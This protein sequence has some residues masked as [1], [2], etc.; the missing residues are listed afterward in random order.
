MSHNGTKLLYFEADDDEE[1]LSNSPPSLD[2]YCVLSLI[3]ERNKHKEKIIHLFHLASLRC[4]LYFQQQFEQNTPTT[5]T[6]YRE[7]IHTACLLYTLIS[8]THALY[9]T[10]TDLCSED[11]FNNLMFQAFNMFE[12][13]FTLVKEFNANFKLTICFDETNL[14]QIQFPMSEFVECCLFVVS[15]FEKNLELVKGALETTIS[16]FSY[17]KYRV[18]GDQSLSIFHNSC[19][20]KCYQTMLDLLGPTE[21]EGVRNEWKLTLDGLQDSIMSQ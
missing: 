6:N 10:P 13:T 1:L 17:A 5:T 12:K 8:D 7:L 2:V 14:T 19:L 3:Q 11:H 21:T 18:G 4:N 16:L 20:A 15:S 9:P